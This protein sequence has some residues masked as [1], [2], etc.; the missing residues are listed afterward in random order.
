MHSELLEDRKVCRAPPPSAK[1]VGQ[2]AL[3]TLQ[4]LD[5]RVIARVAYKADMLG[6]R[7]PCCGFCLSGDIYRE[8]T[9]LQPFKALEG[10]EC[11][12]NPRLLGEH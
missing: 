9:T 12:C 4:R 2:R 1:L 3:P 11:K 6:A 7:G 10:D 5:P 8:A